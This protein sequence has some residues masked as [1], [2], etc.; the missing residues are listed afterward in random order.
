MFHLG[1]PEEVRES[2]K[3]G[4]NGAYGN[5]AMRKPNI[6]SVTKSSDVLG[7][8]SS[9]STAGVTNLQSSFAAGTSSITSLKAPTGSRPV[10]GGIG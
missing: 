7:K 9:L 4:L 3:F 1:K 8:N 5:N 10:I 2:A 6:L